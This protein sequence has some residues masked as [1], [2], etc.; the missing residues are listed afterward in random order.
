MKKI[1]FACLLCALPMMAGAQQVTGQDAPRVSA[2]NT[3]PAPAA[4]A[5]PAKGG[6]KPKEEATGFVPLLGGLG[7]FGGA[8]AAGVA[9]A[10][11]A[12]GGGGGSTPDTQ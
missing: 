4:P 6:E 10:A 2:A 11:L 1:C 8:A 5:D 7:I 3:P 9:A 12:G